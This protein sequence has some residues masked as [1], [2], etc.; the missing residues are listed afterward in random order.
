MESTDFIAPGSTAPLRTRPM[1]EAPA[2]AMLAADLLR[3]PLA[4]VSLTPEEARRVVSYMRLVSFSPGTLVYRE[5]DAGHAGTMLLILEGEV[6]VEAGPG[7]PVAVSVIG[8]GSIIGEMA[9]IDGAPRS[10]S[11]TAVT[12]VR[13][14][15]ISR[16]GLGSLLEEQPR[17]A[18]RLMVGLSQR[19][20]ERLRA[21]GQQIQMHAAVNARLQAELDVL[22]GRRR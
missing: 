21:L 22:R 12:A 9:L 2:L 14:A 19:I 4:L 13:A 8:P 18:A 16:V 20:A 6:S 11:C 17:V 3:T 7:E 1:D 10:V 5:G 15:G